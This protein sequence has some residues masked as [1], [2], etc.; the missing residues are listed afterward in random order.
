MSRI[1]KLFK[2]SKE[3]TV[4]S[5][6]RGICAELKISHLPDANMNDDAFRGWTPWGESGVEQP[7][8]NLVSWVGGERVS[9]AIVRN[10]LHR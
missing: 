6:E 4:C 7:P 1:E 10:E 3:T 2:F 9:P 8:L 5:G